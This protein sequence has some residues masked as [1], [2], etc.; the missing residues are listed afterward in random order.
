MAQRCIDI[1][2]DIEGA[3]QVSASLDFIGDA[4]DDFEQ[5]LKKTTTLLLSVIQKQ[6]DSEGNELLGR[7][8][9][10]LDPVYRA[11]KSKQFPN[12]KILERTGKMRGNFQ[13]ELS[14]ASTAIFN[15]TSYFKFH[16]S[17]LPRQKLPRRIMMKIDIKRQ[18]EIFRFFTVYLNEVA[19]HFGRKK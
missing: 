4:L 2:F 12:K 16:Q 10:A 8:W 6:F 5:P 18:A 14:K 17:K 3:K 7:K 15:P 19:G 1:Q 11:R 13:S 9:V